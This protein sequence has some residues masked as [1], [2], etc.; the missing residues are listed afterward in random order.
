MCTAII[1]DWNTVHIGT[2]HIG[3]HVGTL[4]IGTHIG[5]LHIGTCTPVLNDGCTHI[6]MHIQGYYVSQSIIQD[7]GI[8]GILKYMYP[9]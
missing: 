7:W 8:T 9:Q 5:T 4:H 3:T 1:R 6:C 2:L